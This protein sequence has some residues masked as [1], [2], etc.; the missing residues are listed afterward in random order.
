MTKKLLKKLLIGCLAVCFFSALA[1]YSGYF[2][3][4]KALREENQ[5]LLEQLRSLNSFAEEENAALSERQTASSEDA[6]ADTGEI[7]EEECFLLREQNGRIAVYR[8]SGTSEVLYEQT[9]I[10]LQGL[11]PELQQ[12][13][14]DGKVLSG[15]G[16][17]Y[18]FLENYTS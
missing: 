7:P 15:E 4:G 1:W 6:A 17:L 16:E 18:D 9:D 11:P 3:S 14:H 10:P 8:S 12:E 13:I 5:R 2:Y